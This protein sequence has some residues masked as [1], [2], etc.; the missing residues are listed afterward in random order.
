[1]RPDKKVALVLGA[2]G[3]I[4]SEVTRSLLRRGWLVRALVRGQ[5]SG[6]D[7]AKHPQLEWVIG[8]ALRKQDVIDAA[9]GAAVIVHA[10]NPAKYHNWRGLALPMLDNTI[11]AAALCH[12]T[13]LL[14]GTIY[15]YG[16]AY[17]VVDE[18]TLQ[19]PHTRKGAIRVEMEERL[20]EACWDGRVRS[21]I[22]R[23][24]DFFGAVGNSSW[25][26]QGVVQRGQPVRWVFNPGA[27]DQMHSWAYLPDVAETM[28]RL[29]EQRQSMPAFDT[30]HFKGHVLRNSD[31]MNA[32]CQLAGISRRRVLPFPWW[33]IRA[34]APF[35]ELCKEMREMQYLW[36]QPL[37]LNNAK[38]LA[39]IG[40]EPH[41]PLVDALRTTLMGI[42]CLGDSG[43]SP[44]ARRQAGILR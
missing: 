12:A 38:L 2:N 9:Y 24:G 11:A 6:T 7:A 23:A 20:R 1:M 36:E 26:S 10:V 22:V 34:G 33:A 14:P 21:L 4:G 18:E 19:N 32:V 43:D 5:P 25:F 3:G 29:L 28:V 39:R 13:V 27:T 41:T 17:T 15:N 40:V 16:D 31:L 44:V 8:D 37:E 42:G 30:Y 35:V